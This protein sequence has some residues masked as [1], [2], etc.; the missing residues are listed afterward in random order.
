MRRNRRDA[1]II[2]A[3]Y[4]LNPASMRILLKYTNMPTH[5]PKKI[6]KATDK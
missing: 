1:A 2:S 5:Y 6:L 3:K 4:R